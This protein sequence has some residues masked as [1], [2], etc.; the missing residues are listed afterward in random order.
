MYK[1]LLLI[2]VALSGCSNFK[3]TASMCDDLQ[4]EPGNIEV[5]KECRNYDEDE[6]TKAFEKVVDEK[7]VSDKDIKFD[8]E[9]E[10]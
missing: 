1:I 8:L 6:A 5:P 2:V 9:R 7:K 3:V 10:E 4:R